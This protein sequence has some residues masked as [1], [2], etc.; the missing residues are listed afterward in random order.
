MNWDVGDDST[1]DLLGSREVAQLLKD[2]EQDHL[3][4]D[5]ALLLS[6]FIV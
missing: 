1:W 3:L 5:P 4:L 2:F 6:A